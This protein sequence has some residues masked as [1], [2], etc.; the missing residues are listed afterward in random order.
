MIYLPPSLSGVVNEY[1]IFSTWV[2]HLP[3]AYDLVHELRPRVVVELGTQGGMSYFMFCQAIRDHGVGGKCYA[4]DTWEGDA[5]SGVYEDSVYK[6]VLEYNDARYKDFSELLRTRFEIA[7]DRF[8]DASVD[9]LHIDGFHT[10]EAVRADFESWY[11]KVSPGGIVLFHDIAARLLDFGAWKF[12]NELTRLHATFTFRHGF[13]LGV[14]RKPGSGSEDPPLL[15]LLFTGNRETENNLRAFYVHAA[16][17]WDMLR[18]RT[19]IEAIKARVREK[20]AGRA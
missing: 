9:L 10:Y 4:V 7:V 20:R 11:S 18:Q 14:L 19:M 13:G 16:K 1:N 5:H 6:Q 12:W 17:H 8:P 2:D 3:F 15:S